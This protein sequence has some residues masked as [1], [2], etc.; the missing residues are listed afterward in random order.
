MVGDVQTVV[1]ATVPSQHIAQNDN[2]AVN[3]RGVPMVGYAQ[4]TALSAVPNLHS[5]HCHNTTICHR[6]VP[7]VGAA[8]TIT[9]PATPNLHHSQH[10]NTTEGHRGVPMVGLHTHNPQDTSHLL[11]VSA[12]SPKLLFTLMK[13][14]SSSL[15][16][17]I[18]VP[19]AVR[20]NPCDLMRLR[21]TQMT[22]AEG[23]VPLLAIM[24]TC[25]PL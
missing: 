6:G 18:P 19:Q 7:M 9:Q 4:T 11:R 21:L 25:P 16:V 17:W 5:S 13:M 1:Q 8:Q 20:T 15:S 12:R 14:H 10:D 2:A 22:S 24:L 3:H 23:Q